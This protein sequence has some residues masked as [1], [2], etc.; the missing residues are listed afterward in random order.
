MTVTG[1]LLTLLYD[2]RVDHCYEFFIYLILL[3]LTDPLQIVCL[4]MLL[5]IK[6]NIIEVGLQ[7]QA[8]Q[9]TGATASKLVTL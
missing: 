4:F 5:K 7:I 6:Q 3:P 1:F 8:N 9:M 2:K